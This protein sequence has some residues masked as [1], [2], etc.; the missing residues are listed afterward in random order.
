MEEKS[1]KEAKA[2][3]SEDQTKEANLVGQENLKADLKAAQDEIS[4]F[5]DEAEKL[6]KSNVSLEVEVG[7]I[8]KER[9]SL[10]D[11]LSQA[12]EKHLKKVQDLESQIGTLTREKESAQGH[13]KKI[14]E[15]SLT[16]KS[17]EESLKNKISELERN[18]NECNTTSLF[19]CL[20]HLVT[21]MSAKQQGSSRVTLDDLI[22]AEQELKK[23][24]ISFES[25][26]SI[27]K[28][29]KD[30]MK[31]LNELLEAK[32]VSSTVNK[33]LDDLEESTKKLSAVQLEKEQLASTTEL[34]DLKK[35]LEQ[36][37]LE[38]NS[39]T[40]TISSLTTANNKL[41][42]DCN[43]LKVE[44]E[45]LQLNI[46][47]LEKELQ[48]ASESH[49]FELEKLREELVKFKEENQ[50]QEFHYH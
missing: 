41:S 29:L 37:K 15:E 2:S 4:K 3:E 33:L 44:K 17:S 42:D 6:R 19:K 27:P 5:R 21:S 1:Q 7:N 32:K 13:L 20:N 34:D 45:G 23:E 39:L 8:S 48:K 24:C 12:N 50:K 38:K 14:Q 36:I 18:L 16:W 26:T 43:S 47:S 28:E 30:E 40:D 25:K 46:A 35:E 31:K 22:K 49:N 9:D 11:E 10:K